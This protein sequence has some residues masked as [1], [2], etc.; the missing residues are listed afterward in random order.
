MD[1]FVGQKASISKTISECDIYNYAGITGDFNP[2]HINE[3]YAKDTQ[4]KSRIAHGMLSAGMISSVIGTQLPGPGSIYMGQTLRFCLPVKIGDTITATV[5]V[6]EIIP[7]KH[8]IILETICYN[9]N[10]A[11]VLTGEAK[12]FYADID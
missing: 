11:E 4:F 7:E 12:V 9:Q 8:R 3:C 2:V 10:G 5:V 6:K 1:I